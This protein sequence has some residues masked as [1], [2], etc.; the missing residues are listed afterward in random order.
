MPG[1]MKPSHK[2]DQDKCTGDIQGILGVE[3]EEYDT[4]TVPALLFKSN[5]SKE[6]S[7]MGLV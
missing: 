3:S 1:P 6:K 2:Q 5:F 4:N 7:A